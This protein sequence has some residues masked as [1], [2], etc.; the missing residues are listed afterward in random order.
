MIGRKA[1]LRELE[2]RYSSGK[3]EMITVYGRRR[4]GKTT[5]LKE[6]IKGRRGVYFSATRG[7]LESNISSLASKVLGTSAPTS[8]SPEDLLGEVGRLSSDER[9]VL[10]IDE[11]PNLLRRD[12]RFSDILQEFID[13]IEHGSK[14]FLI[15][16][17]SSIS[18]MK[19]QVL[20]SAS[21][22]YGRRTGQLEVL[23]M[24][25]WDS[26]EFLDGFDRE[27][28]LRIYGM[29][30]GIPL[31]LG[32]FDPRESLE[33]NVRRLFFQESSFFRNEHEFVL[34]E[35]FD[36]PFTYYTVLEAMARGR[37][38]VSEIASYCSLD[39]STVH[40]HLKALLATQFVE[41]VAPVDNP[42][43][44]NVVY[45]I[46]D[47]F[48]EFQFGRILPVADYYDP[49]DPQATV[50]QVMAGLENDMGRV[51]EVICGQHLVRTHRGRLGRWWG[52]DPVAHTQEE[53]D[54]VL[55]KVMDGRTVG[56]FAE[57]KFKS[58]PTGTDVLEK[59]RHRASL[60]SG[61]DETRLVLYSKS[62]FTGGLT[63]DPTVELY[64]LDDVL[65]RRRAGEA[66][67]GYGYRIWTST[68]IV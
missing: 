22:I 34:I 64:G 67:P 30:G 25:I 23:P 39:D 2:D 60:V 55:T 19:H 28:M 37:T 47:P 4:V 1:E 5:L 7:S 46:S 54:L 18:I 3:F 17:G 20:S 8:M 24:D 62:G 68:V 52:S 49:D 29:V 45:R 15:L 44:K 42:R 32:M 50:G 59:L 11:Y 53:I 26:M 65:R 51:F 48:L 61:F 9:Y 41:K 43:G 27:D 40:K 63:G 13:D 31:Y 16:C 56:W 14:L 36:N 21:P 58:V 12:D 38:R 57:C 33:R 6:F 35:E 10:I 66:T